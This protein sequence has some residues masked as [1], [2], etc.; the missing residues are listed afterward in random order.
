MQKTSNNSL[1]FENIETVR[2]LEAP[3]A[4]TIKFANGLFENFKDKYGISPKRAALHQAFWLYNH[5]MKDMY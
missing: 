4:Q 5:E 3:S 2:P 1:N